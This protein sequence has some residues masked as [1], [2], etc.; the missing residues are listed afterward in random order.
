[1]KT[2]E[3]VF[4]IPWPAEYDDAPVNVGSYEFN[5]MD[6]YYVGDVDRS[7]NYTFIKTHPNQTQNLEATMTITPA[8]L[9]ITANDNSVTYGM[10]PADKGVRYSGLKNGNDKGRERLNAAVKEHILARAQE[11]LDNNDINQGEYDALENNLEI[12]FK[13][14]YNVDDENGEPTV[15][16]TYANSNNE[17]LGVFVKQGLDAQ[18]EEVPADEAIGIRH[19]YAQNG[20]PGSYA[21]VPY[22]KSGYSAPNYNIKF[23]NGTL[24]VNDK[25][26]TL[27]AKGTKKGSKGVKI[28]WNSVT[29]AASYDVYAAK[30]NTK[31]RKR[32]PKYVATV[33]GNSYKLK[34]LNGKKL[35]KNTCYKYYV[36]AKNAAGAPIATSLEGHFI[37]GNVKG[38]T[39]NAKSMAVNTASVSVGKG[40]TAQLSASY[41]KAKAGK[42]YKLNNN[43]HSALTR[44][45]SENP[46]VATVDANGIVRGVGTGWCRVYVQGVTGMWTVVEVN[47]K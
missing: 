39:V 47:V 30:C 44:F 28:S 34:K 41:K 21:I 25:V 26:S 36:V 37:T 20:K 4:V 33:S 13:T 1:M 19:T 38:K 29:G 14:P 40:G 23:V 32:S 17:S 46:A 15:H 3:E 2:D 5:V 9:T 27:V 11:R 31:G 16:P 42:K 18:D 43:A 6:I 24:N 8:P 35:Q 22:L 10:P 7:M 45:V 12:M